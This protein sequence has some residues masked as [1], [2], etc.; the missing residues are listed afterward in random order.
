LHPTNAVVPWQAPVVSD[1]S[2]HAT[3]RIILNAHWNNNHGV[4]PAGQFEAQAQS[5]EF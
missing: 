1:G 4:A 2:E 3:D 5:R